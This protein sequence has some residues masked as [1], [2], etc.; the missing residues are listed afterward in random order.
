M[1]AVN[2]D[3]GRNDPD[4]MDPFVHLSENFFFFKENRF[5]KDDVRRICAMLNGE[6]LKRKTRSKALNKELQVCIAINFFARGSISDEIGINHRVDV[7]TVS[8][9]IGCA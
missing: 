1:A 7:A 2:E 8:P 9:Y 6:D 3:V 4:K 5:C